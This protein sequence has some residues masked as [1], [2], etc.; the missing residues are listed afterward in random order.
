MLLQSPQNF[1][2]WGTRVMR[3]ESISEEDL[4]KRIHFDQLFDRKVGFIIKFPSGHLI[5]TLQF[6]LFEG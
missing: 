4:G 1:R 6:Y 2:F 3:K 5:I